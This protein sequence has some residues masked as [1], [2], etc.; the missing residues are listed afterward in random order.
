MADRP[1]PDCTDKTSPDL[2]AAAAPSLHVR[3]TLPEFDRSTWQPGDPE[4]ALFAADGG[5][6]RLLCE[7]GTV[8]DGVDEGTL[9]RIGDAIAEGIRR[10]EAIKDIGCSSLGVTLS[11]GGGNGLVE[12]AGLVHTPAFLSEMEAPVALPVTVFAQRP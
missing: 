6:R 7:A 1:D 10:G 2:R 8:I 9:D 3:F 4:A 5:L 11:G 12:V